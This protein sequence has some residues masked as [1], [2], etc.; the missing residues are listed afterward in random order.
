MMR[1]FPPRAADRWLLRTATAALLVGT[2]VLAQNAAAPSPTQNGATPN[3]ITYEGFLSPPAEIAKT[4][5]APRHLNV[6]LSNPSPDRKFFIKAQSEGMPTM[7]IFAKPHYYLGGVQVDHRANR[8]RSL[9]T[10]AGTGFS[11]IDWETGKSV[12]VELPRGATATNPVWSR[13]GREIAYFAHFDNATHIYIANATTGKSRALTKTPVL[14]TLVTSFEWTA[15]GKSIVT[16]LIPDGRGVEPKLPDVPSQPKIRV[17]QGTKAQTRTYA[18]LLETPHDKALLEYYTTGQLAVIDVKTGA[19]RKIGKPAMIQ[20]VDASP[21]GQYFRVTQMQ[22]PFS[23]IVPVQS[24]GNR[25]ELWDPT[26]K[27]VLE[28]AKRELREGAGPGATDDDPAPAAQA[29]RAAADTAKRSIAW[30]PVGAG[31]IYL[32]QEAAP[33]RGGR[34]STAAAPANANH[35]RRKDRLYQW[36]PPYDASSAKV[37]YES[38]SRMHNVR[39]SDDGQVLFLT[40][41]GGE[42]AVYLTEPG[43]RYTISRGRGGAGGRGGGGG[44]GAQTPAQLAAA[45]SAFYNAPGSLM[46]KRG[47]NGAAVVQ[48]TSD[49]SAVYLS[50]TKYFPNPAKDAPRNFVDRLDLKTGNKTRVFESDGQIWESVSEVLDDDFGRVIV[51]RES[52][53]MVPDFYFRDLKG[54]TLKKLTNNVDYSPELTRAIRKIIPVE[55]VD[56]YKFFVN[57]T[58]PPDYVQGTKLPA[59]FWFYPREFTDQG[60][61]DRTRRTLNKTRFPSVSTRDMDILTKLGY[62]VV[63][64]DAPIVGENGRMNDNYV[65][66]LRN[67]LTAVIDT[68]VSQGYIDRNRIGIGGHSYGAFSTVNAMVHTPYFKAGIAGDGNYLRPLTPNGFQSER[69]DLWEA[70]ETYLEMSPLL[71]ADKLNGALL[72]YHGMADQNVGTA[73]INSERLYHALMGLGKTASL[74]MYPYEDHGPA[75]RETNLDL[76]AR[77]VAWLDLYVKNPKKEGIAIMH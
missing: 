71:Y 44:G 62:A 48:M 37:L 6:T 36:M 53:T 2:P 30:N 76:W 43:K 29:A 12:S 47:P 68:L 23:Y 16:V 74:Y 72:M 56:G 65:S 69:R 26:G 31:M 45:D 32:Q 54:G 61:Y 50:G 64:P 25:E 19:V 8:A 21:D 1:V 60:S 9:T 7:A 67:N 46:T 42:F 18:S 34:D 5:L 10:R 24:F 57:I 14:A 39:F 66:D 35:P 17:T 55:R 41:E 63:E 27:V 59:M 11:V 22:H 40:D 77:W 3:P 13:D 20:S 49:K 52:P 73:P 51:S 38:D 4:V 15:D 75:T 70:R 33:R 28:I 58:L